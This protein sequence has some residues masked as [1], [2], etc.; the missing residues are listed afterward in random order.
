MGGFD[1]FWW[2]MMDGNTV[3]VD[4][5]G[6]RFWDIVVVDRM[7]MEHLKLREIHIFNYN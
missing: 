5:S 1:G 2:V 6:G 7:N 3:A 4:R